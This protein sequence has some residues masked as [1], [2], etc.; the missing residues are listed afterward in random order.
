MHERHEWKVFLFWPY[1]TLLHYAC[2]VAERSR[3][4]NGTVTNSKYSEMWGKDVILSHHP[5]DERDFVALQ[6]TSLLH[7]AQCLKISN[8][9]MSSSDLL[10]RPR[11]WLAQKHTR[12]GQRKGT[13]TLTP[14]F[15][16]ETLEPGFFPVIMCNNDTSSALFEN[17]VRWDAT[18][19]PALPHRHNSHFHWIIC[20]IYY[21]K[22]H[23][24]MWLDAK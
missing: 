3:R 16:P 12:G 6:Q 22:Y 7:V 2:D 18:T 24:C 20:I 10:S 15:I 8:Q 19:Q 5:A 21:L 23:L 4:I 13:Y 11:T 14:H 1:V 9:S 17:P